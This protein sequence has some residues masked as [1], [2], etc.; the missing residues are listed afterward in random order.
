MAGPS[1][2]HGSL[3]VMG[4]AET[5]DRSARSYDASRRT[6]VPCFDGFYGSALDALP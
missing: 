2:S 6:L 1:A 3:S 5:F 4:V